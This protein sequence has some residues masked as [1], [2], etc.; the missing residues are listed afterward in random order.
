MKDLDT[1]I[2][3]TPVHFG[4]IKQTIDHGTRL[5]VEKRGGGVMEIALSWGM[6]KLKRPKEGDYLIQY[7]Q[8]HIDI[9]T[10][11]DFS[12]KIVAGGACVH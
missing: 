9:I 12:A 10:A 4:R 8:G 6:A 5:F 11:E 2:F 7:P 3:H 1:A